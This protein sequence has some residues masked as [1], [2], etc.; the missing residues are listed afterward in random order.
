[1]VRG[2]PHRDLHAIVAVVNHA[3]EL[4]LEQ[5]PKQADR[6]QDPP[7]VGLVSN[8]LSAVLGDLAVRLDLAPNLIASGQDIKQ[9]VRTAAMGTRCRRIVC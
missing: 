4:P 5:C 6:E 9:L 2:L 3:R 1:M 7:Q 8:V